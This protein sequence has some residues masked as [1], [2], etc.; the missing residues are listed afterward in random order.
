[1]VS[2]S[3]VPAFIALRFSTH[4]VNDSVKQMAGP[5]PRGCHLE[6]WGEVH[7]F[8]FLIS[9]QVMPKLLVHTPHFSIDLKENPAFSHTFLLFSC[10]Q[11]TCGQY[12][13]DAVQVI[14][15]EFKI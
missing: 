6:V 7:G 1:M 15:R 12:V 11:K 5:S 9:P 10:H 8:A 3:G 13:L 4:L 14:Y 2:P